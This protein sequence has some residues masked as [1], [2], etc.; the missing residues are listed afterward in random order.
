MKQYNLYVIAHLATW[1]TLKVVT[2]PFT[3]LP[4]RDGVS[5]L[6]ALNISGFQC[7]FNQGNRFLCT[8]PLEKL[9]S[10]VLGCF[11]K[12]SVVL[13]WSYHAI[14]KLIW[15]V[16]KRWKSERDPRQVGI[17]QISIHFP[18]EILCRSDLAYGIEI[19]PSWKS[20]CDIPE[21]HQLFPT[22]HGQ[23]NT[24]QSL[25]QPNENHTK[26]SK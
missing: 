12:C 2:N 16:E 1:S 26:V 14:R 17:S 7:L 23:A 15:G 3:I 20:E 4:L 19:Q 25:M 21:E 18:K 6:S 10:E 9:K 5:A 13:K 24:K 22:G 8:L 11:V